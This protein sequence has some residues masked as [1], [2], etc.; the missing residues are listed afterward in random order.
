MRPAWFRC[1]NVPFLPGAS[2]Y[3]PERDVEKVFFDC[4]AIAELSDA[5]LPVPFPVQEILTLP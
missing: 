2:D 5:Y 4:F 3:G 1:S